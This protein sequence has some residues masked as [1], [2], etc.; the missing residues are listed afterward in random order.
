LPWRGR[1]G[2]KAFEQDAGAATIYQFPGSPQDEVFCAFHVD[3]HEVDIRVATAIQT[4]G[5]NIDDGAL[6]CHVFHVSFT[7]GTHREV[8]RHMKSSYAV[9]I[10]DRH[11]MDGYS[12]T[13]FIDGH[14]ALD[15]VH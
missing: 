15:P 10:A 5:G 3:F 8:L 2:V 4:D 7:Q 13:D 11:G 14:V 12:L 1:W 6:Q 9:G